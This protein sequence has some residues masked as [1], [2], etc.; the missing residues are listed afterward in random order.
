MYK[1]ESFPFF[2]KANFTVGKPS[3][4]YRYPK[5][6]IENQA[7][8]YAVKLAKVGYYGGDPLKIL[9]APVDVVMDILNYEIFDVNY[10]EAFRELN[11]DG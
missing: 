5:V 11:K 6:T 10:Q 3:D 4:S 9:D 7:R 2:R 8:F 1:G